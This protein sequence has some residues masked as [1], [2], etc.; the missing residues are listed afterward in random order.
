M[1][2]INSGIDHIW[3][4]GRT[5]MSKD[6]WKWVNENGEVLSRNDIGNKRSWCFDGS[7]PYTDREVCLNLDRESRD[8]PLFY[9]LPCNMTN[10]Y[11]LCNLSARRSIQSTFAEVNETKVEQN[12]GKVSL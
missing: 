10:Q 6:G 8:T 7:W 12:M 11:V 1:S 3:V 2:Q 9:G 4:G 5:I